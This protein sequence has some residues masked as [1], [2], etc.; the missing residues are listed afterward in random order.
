MSLAIS[1]TWNVF[2]LVVHINVLISIPHLPFTCTCNCVRFPPLLFV[3]VHYAIPLLQYP[4][5]A[6]VPGFLHPGHIF[7]T[8]YMYM[9]ISFSCIIV[10][11]LVPHFSQ[12]SSNRYLPQMDLSF[13]CIPI[14]MAKSP[15][16]PP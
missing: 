9:Y 7:C 11:L 12:P 3:E 2:P 1:L 14:Q 13:S 15:S 5:H 6:I 8:S 16:K 10:T 4:R